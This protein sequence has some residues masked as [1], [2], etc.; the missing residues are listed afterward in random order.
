MGFDLF[1]NALQP[2]SEALW[3]SIAQ[4]IINSG[5]IFM[6]G[7]VYRTQIFV[8]DVSPFGQVYFARYFD[9]QGRA[10]EEFLQFLMP[11]APWLLETFHILTV[12]ASVNYHKPL[13][14]HE[15]VAIEVRIE[16]LTKT[17][18][19]LAFVYRNETSGLIVAEGSQR[20]VFTNQ[21]GQILPLPD[22]VEIYAHHYMNFQA[23][24]AHVPNDSVC[25]PQSP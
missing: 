7:F 6:S 12:E 5:G 3:A 17:S 8:E 15:R 14:L 23:L 4:T 11:T 16:K 18:V 9:W 19:T 20:L 22:D 10:R 21:E 24:P 2:S 13:F 25:Q 1:L